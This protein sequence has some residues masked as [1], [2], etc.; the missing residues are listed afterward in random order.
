MVTVAPY[1]RRHPSIRWEYET[2]NL[3]W[4]AYDDDASDAIED[5]YRVFRHDSSRDDV[6][7]VKSG[8]FHYFV[9]FP[10]MEQTNIDHDAQRHR[11]I[12]RTE[13]AA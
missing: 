6:H 5:E 3:G 7:T 2:Q 1:V 10:S 9:H 11:A 8:Q 4:Q 12:R 13:L